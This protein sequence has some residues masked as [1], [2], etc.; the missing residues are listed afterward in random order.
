MKLYTEEELEK[1]GNKVEEIYEDEIANFNDIPEVKESKI[2]RFFDLGKLGKKNNDLENEF[3]IPNVKVSKT[4]KIKMWYQTKKEEQQLK[5]ET[6]KINKEAKKEIRKVKK[7]ERNQKIK[8]WYND[9]KEA[10]KL[11]KQEQQQLHEK[12]I[13]T[14]K[15]LLK[16]FAK[17]ALQV[18]LTSVALAGGIIAA[19]SVFTIGFFSTLVITTAFAVA[20]K[21]FNYILKEEIEEFKLIKLLCSD[22]EEEKTESND[23]EKTK[24]NGFFKSLKNRFSKSKDDS[25]EPVIEN[26][27]TIID[28]ESEELK[29][30]ENSVNNINVVSPI[31]S[32]VKLTR[33]QK[34]AKVKQECQLGRIKVNDVTSYCVFVA[35]EDIKLQKFIRSEYRKENPEE[36]IQ[37]FELGEKKVLVLENRPNFK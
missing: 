1:I 32:D 23:E 27:S 2:Q 34:I 12:G 8:I 11:K 36:K 35:K 5:K 30:V 29:Q 24:K 15:D 28:V 16:S 19:T 26:E 14:K 20:Y 6:R 25:K 7:Q 21:I 37:S 31:T 3:D 18:V 33:E 22:S 10:R 4:E 9:K 13:Y 17:C